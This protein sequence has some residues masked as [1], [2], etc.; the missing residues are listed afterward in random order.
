[1]AK[2]CHIT[3]VDFGFAR[4]LSPKDIDDDAGFKK[5]VDGKENQPEKSEGAKEF[6][7][8]I[9]HALEDNLTAGE[10]QSTQS[11][12]RSRTREDNFDASISHKKIRDLSKFFS[13]HNCTL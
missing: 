4:A 8:S 9:D 6:Y 2:Q 1:M 3:L 13:I 10:K 5:V 11:R 7:A 12:G